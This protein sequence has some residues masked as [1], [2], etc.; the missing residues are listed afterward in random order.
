MICVSRDFRDLIASC[1][2]TFNESGPW[3]FNHTTI[4]ANKQILYPTNHQ[5][6]P[7][8][9]PPSPAVIKPVSFFASIEC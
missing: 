5:H 3:L 4:L 8:V 9:D 7:A 1:R 6:H 2:L